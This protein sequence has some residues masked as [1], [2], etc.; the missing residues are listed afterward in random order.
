M[1]ER[2]GRKGWK[3]TTYYVVEND[4]S[5]KFHENICEAK[6][7]RHRHSKGG[8]GKQQFAAAKIELAKN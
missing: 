3:E 5:K 8:D 2:P 1:P 7:H 4:V 6:G